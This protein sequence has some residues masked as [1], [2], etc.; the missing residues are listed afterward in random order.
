M[1][2]VFLVEDEILI[3]DGIKN[4]IS[5]NEFGF[6]FAG[7]AADGELAWPL[8][9]KLKPDIVITDIKMPFMDG[10]ALSK[11]I[12]K[13][14]PQ[15][16]III[17]SGYD[18][19]AYAKEAISI[20]VSQYLLKPLS[21]DQL[22]EILIDIKKQRDEVEEKERYRN[23]FNSEIEEYRTSSRRNF[24]DMLVGGKYSVSQLLEH[25][26]KFGLDL[27]AECYNIV[28][29][30]FEEELLQAGYSPQ[31]DDLQ[32]KLSECIP[33][34]NVVMFS[35]GIDMLVFLIK[36]DATSIA[37]ETELCVNSLK[38]LCSPFNDTINTYIVVGEP[39][40]RLSAV[41]DCYRIARKRL[42]R[43][44]EEVDV[45]HSSGNH[46]VVVD[47]NP[48][49]MNANMLDQR[50]IEK[51]LHNGLEDEIE[52]FVHDYFI[53]I[54][55]ESVKSMMF[56]QY[57]VLNIQFTINAFI[58]KLNCPK[59]SL[60]ASPDALREAI[61]TLEGA[62][63]YICTLLRN[64]IQLRE[65]AVN[66]RYS[67]MLGKAIA[68]IDENFADPDISLSAV[69]KTANVSATHFSAVF[70]Q[71]MNKTF[72]EYLTEKRM[73][74]AKELLRCSDK[75]SGEIALIVG[76]NDP[77]YFSFLFKKINGCSP[78]NYRSGKKTNNE[79]T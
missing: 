14:L 13:E 70:S 54:G 53:S 56:R 4:L 19:F 38:S 1:Y 43:R 7:E 6:I 18:D 58:E 68:Y 12:K 48:D 63:K 23:R 79:I 26:A 42:F 61:P 27:T 46:N 34:N 25:S 52:V 33:S 59:D 17:V 24:L 57:L 37:N 40:Q 29:F 21:K 64:A 67:V 78:K 62:E 65:K 47:F 71:E 9:Q 51:F 28:L 30:L 41:A 55:E 66:N 31:L 3:R 22:V 45:K 39:V 77:H 32:A 10:L 16:T 20:G 11:L 15:T 50:I 74:K 36:S 60:I 69:A 35:L 75:T 72:V 49:E 8:I 73:D 5:W 76:Y 2:S 44:G